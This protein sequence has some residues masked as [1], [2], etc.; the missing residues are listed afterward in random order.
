[1][2]AGERDDYAADEQ[3]T[4]ADDD[5]RL[6]WLESGDG[7]EE[8]EGVDGGRIFGFAILALIALAAFVGGIWWF[9]NRGESSE[10]LADGSTIE[11]PE[12]P[13]KTRP[14][15]PGG[16][17][18]E[19]TG[20]LAPAVGEGRETEGRI[21]EA[22]PR[23]S[24][25]VPRP[26]DTPSTAPSSAP[27]AARGT[28][29]QVGAYSNKADA[30]AGW[31]QLQRQTEHLNGVSH[32]VVQGQADIGTVFRLQATPGDAAAASRLCTALKGDGVACQVK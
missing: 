31:Q 13:Y 7:D 11:A 10:V 29:V 16:K 8:D 21:A 6:P 22:A 20:N 18:F 24:I 25:D 30:E 32:R 15:D 14:T 3:L 28:V 9:G 26:S 19:G 12:G 23:P 5:E 1:M 2:N 17:Q 4:L 27:A